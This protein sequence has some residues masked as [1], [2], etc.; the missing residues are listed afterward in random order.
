MRGAQGDDIMA[1]EPGSRTDGL[2]CVTDISVTRDEPP[3]QPGVGGA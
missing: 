2:M 1:G 3:P